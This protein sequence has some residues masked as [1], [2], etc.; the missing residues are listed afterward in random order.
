MQEKALITARPKEKLTAPL[1]IASH[2]KEIDNLVKDLNYQFVT[3]KTKP[4]E[5]YFLE[6]GE[7][8][9][10][11]H[12]RTDGTMEF[13]TTD[14]KKNKPDEAD[15]ATAVRAMLR[16]GYALDI[17]ELQFKDDD[18]QGKEKEVYKHAFEDEK[19]KLQA[20]P[21]P[22]QE[23]DSTPKGNT[24]ISAGS[25]T[26]ASA[27]AAG[28]RHY[29][30]FLKLHKK[31]IDNGLRELGFVVDTEKHMLVKENGPTVYVHDNGNTESNYLSPHDKNFVQS[32]V[33]AHLAVI[34]M[35]A[36]LFYLSESKIPFP[37]PR[38]LYMI[39]GT[40]TADELTKVP[41]LEAQI[42]EQLQKVLGQAQYKEIRDHFTYDGTP[43]MQKKVA[44]KAAPVIPPDS[45][46][47]VDPANLPGNTNTGNTS[48]NNNNNL[49]TLSK[50][51]YFQLVD[52]LLNP[53]P[54]VCALALRDIIQSQ[55]EFLMFI[56]EATAERSGGFK[57]KTNVEMALENLDFNPQDFGSSSW[58]SA[59]PKD[60]PKNHLGHA[61]CEACAKL[62]FTQNPFRLLNNEDI[63]RLQNAITSATNTPRP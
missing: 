46:D 44:A 24:G 59:D 6:H 19:Q 14:S 7:T 23:A 11:I 39:K 17:E 58:S 40:L 21:K 45:A 60:V 15:I 16:V 8:N 36:S 49:P 61:L 28:Q 41:A 3:L 54:R 12:I 10:R 51:N 2:W 63:F 57:F 5:T 1:E 20:K 26:P 22:K 48:L 52:D 29:H 9:H 55:S 56:S 33:E 13:D 47:Q 43:I 4:A 42:I 27:G 31:E 38:N 25:T 18:F 37:K 34:H 53:D 62:G 30:V 32:Q 35:D 50:V